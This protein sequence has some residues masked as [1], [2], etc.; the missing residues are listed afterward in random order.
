MQLYLCLSVVLL[1]FAAQ[2]K[3]RMGLISDPGSEES[4]KLFIRNISESEPFKFLIENDYLE[5]SQEPVRLSK[6]ELGCRNNVNGIKR[7]AR[8]SFANFDNSAILK[9]RKSITANYDLM[10]IIADVEGAGGGGGKHP[11]FDRNFPTTVMLHE[12]LHSMGFADE[13]VYTKKEAEIYCTPEALEKSKK[14][15]SAHLVNDGK[16]MENHFQNQ[17]LAQDACVKFIPWCQ[18]AIKQGNTVVSDVA[19]TI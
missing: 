8:C 2:A 1:S 16:I 14:V 7:L 3:Y 17:T 11:V 10:P 5:I 9:K 15:N 18:E 13:Y 19:W 6:E 12:I 4:A